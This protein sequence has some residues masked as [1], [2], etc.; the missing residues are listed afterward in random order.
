MLG[1]PRTERSA[2]TQEV[3][4]LLGIEDLLGR[5]PREL[6]GGQRQRVAMGR[7]LVRRPRAFLMDEPLSNLD[8]MLRVQMR[9]ELSQLQRRLGITTMYV[10]H[11][12]TEAMTLGDRIAVLHRG[13]LQ[14]LGTSEEI[15][16]RPANLFVA[17]FVGSPQMNLLKASLRGG[18]I[19]AG[20]LRIEL[21][22]AL[23]AARLPDAAV[24]GVRPEDLRLVDAGANNGSLAATASVVELLGAETYAYFKV[25]GVDTVDVG[26]RS[27]ELRGAMVA[28]LEAWTRLQPGEAVELAINPAEVH[29]FDEGSGQRLRAAS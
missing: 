5:R 15:Y 9:A 14:Q 7:A 28:R 20:Q 6:S 21:P 12:Q 22:P 29:L 1:V 16:R 2:R 13:R 26:E 10:T 4:G 27:V 3:A 11:D 23:R 18:Q 24:L 25:P 17:S 19:V 8:A